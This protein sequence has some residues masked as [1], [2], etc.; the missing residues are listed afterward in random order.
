MYKLHGEVDVNPDHEANATRFRNPFTKVVL[1][2]YE[3][4]NYLSI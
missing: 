4:G 3:V 2:D 1:C